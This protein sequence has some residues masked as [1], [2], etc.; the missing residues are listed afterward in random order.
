MSAVASGG[1]RE[2]GQGLRWAATALVVAGLHAGAGWWVVG[3]PFLPP[4]PEGVAGVTVD[5]E[6]VSVP[7]QPAAD[8]KPIETAG[9]APAPQAAEAPEPSAEP[10]T[11]A[12]PPHEPAPVEPTPV[13]AAPPLQPPVLDAEPPRPP[14]PAPAAVRDIAL[15]PAPAPPDAVVAPAPRPAPP[16]KRL[17]APKP[18]KPVPPKPDPREVARREARDAQAEAREQAREEAQAAHRAAREQAR[19]ERAAAARE[20]GGADRAS[21]APVASGAAV[22]SWRGEV[23]A[24]LNAYKPASP[25]GSGGTVHVAFSVDRGGRVTS[26][27]VSGSSGDPALDQAAVSMVRRASPVPPPPPELGGRISLAVPV[28]FH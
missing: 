25:D 18:L 8:P 1:G 22:S 19:A 10:H 23:V 14:D 12:G 9:P 15:P 13:E 24:H 5:L 26:A 16:L 11:E 7:V 2:P 28:R 20:G 27:S 21:A 6:P 3:R 4:P 17:A